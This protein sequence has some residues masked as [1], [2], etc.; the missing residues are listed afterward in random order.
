MITV[1]YTKQTLITDESFELDYAGRVIDV[2][3]LL[4]LLRGAPGDIGGWP[5]KIAKRPGSD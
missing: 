4:F 1:K 2:G 3:L 5:P